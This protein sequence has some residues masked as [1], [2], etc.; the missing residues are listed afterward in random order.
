MCSSDLSVN[1]GTG[2][3]TYNGTLTTTQNTTL[4]ATNVSFNDN[5]T[6]TGSLAVVGAST[7]NGAALTTTGAQS[8]SGPVTLAR[9][10][11]VS[12]GSA[13]VPASVTLSDSVD[14][15]YDLTIH[16][17]GDT[18]FWGKV[19]DSVAL[20][21]LTTDATGAGLDRKSTRLNSSH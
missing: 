5:V 19:G 21:S 18:T 17:A 15:A 20:N 2:N 13:G 9:N 16:S 4:T 11:T 3:Q 7:W 14:G 1:T 12:A 10:V 6:V 8:Y